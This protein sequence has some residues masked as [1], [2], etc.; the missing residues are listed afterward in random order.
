MGALVLS[1]ALGLIHGVVHAP[2]QA[3]VSHR[4]VAPG[5]GHVHG[6]VQDGAHAHAHAHALDGQPLTTPLAGSADVVATEPAVAAAEQATSDP[7]TGWL[8]GLF[9]GAEHA[10]HCPLYDQLSHADGLAQAL[11]VGLCNVLSEALPPWHGPSLMA[12][13]AAGYLARGPP[14]KRAC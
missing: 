8:A 12:A 1:Q 2:G 14:V 13:Q 6:L 5:F 4:V 7:P 3:V 10:D 11:A 9:A